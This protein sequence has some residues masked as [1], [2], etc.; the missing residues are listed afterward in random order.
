VVTVDLE[1]PG[2]PSTWRD[3]IPQHPKDLLQS[4]VA[5][6]GDAL[7]VRHLRDVKAALAL[8]K[9]SSGDKVQ[10]SASRTAQC[11]TGMN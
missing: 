1:S 4:A 10:V 7:V 11:S 5:L 6:K 3:I 2:A 9:L 8:H